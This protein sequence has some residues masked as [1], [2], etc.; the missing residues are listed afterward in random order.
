MFENMRADASTSSIGSEKTNF[1]RREIRAFSSRH[2]D[3]NREEK[4][5]WKYSHLEERLFQMERQCK[6]LA[7]HIDRMEAIK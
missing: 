2:Y 1:T 3:E 7:E 4:Q 6:L 5:R